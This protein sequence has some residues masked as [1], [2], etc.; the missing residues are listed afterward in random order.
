MYLLEVL[1][2]HYICLHFNKAVITWRLCVDEAR[3][4]RAKYFNLFSHWG[5]S[6]GSL[7]H[8]LGLIPIFFHLNELCTPLPR[9]GFFW[10]RL[11]KTW[12]F[13]EMLSQRGLADLIHCSISMHLLGLSCLRFNGWGHWVVIWVILCV[14]AHL[15]QSYSS[16][17]GYEY[18][19]C[20]A[21]D[22]ALIHEGTL[23]RLLCK[24]KR[25]HSIA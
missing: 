6:L 3:L 13:Q 1:V 25:S 15:E 5:V 23:Q 17:R 18:F 22:A 11:S 9:C 7:M 10:L 19:L 4:E 16:R 12:L 2:A 24:W 8:L 20:R 14:S 21:S